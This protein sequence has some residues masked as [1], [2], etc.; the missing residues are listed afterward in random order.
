M[1]A[2]TSL[3]YA[4]RTGA[5][6]APA[7][8]QTAEYRAL[9]VQCLPWITPSSSESSRFHRHSALF[10]RQD[11]GT[12][13]VCPLRSVS[14]RIVV[15][16]C[17]HDIEEFV[18]CL[19]FSPCVESLMLQ[20][21]TYHPSTPTAMTSLKGRQIVCSKRPYRSPTFSH[22]HDSWIAFLE[23]RLLFVIISCLCV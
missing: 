2:Y 20:H 5:I 12:P 10:S 8:P 6:H 22:H 23:S 7:D 18:K 16:Q 15:R 17:T 4:V 19:Q 11:T 3:V 13:T 21:G 9:L 14:R 1:G